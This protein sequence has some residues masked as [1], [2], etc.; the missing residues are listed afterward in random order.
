[1]CGSSG[2][3]GTDV[4]TWQRKAARNRAQ[5]RSL[6]RVTNRRNNIF[7]ETR[8]HASGK[9]AVCV[10]DGSAETRT[11]KAEAMER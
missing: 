9:G 7:T 3:S 8:A 5:Q 1:M 2:R 10:Q 6:A 11:L 4:K